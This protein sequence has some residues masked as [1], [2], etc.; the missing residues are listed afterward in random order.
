MSNKSKF[1][2]SKKNSF[3]LY[4]SKSSLKFYEERY[5][6]DYMRD[7]PESKKKKVTQIIKEINLPAYG[8]ALDFGCG[9]GVFTEVIRTC[10]PNWKVYGTDISS[11]AI[12]NAKRRFP[13]C[14]FFDNSEKN[15]K[16]KSFDFIFTNHV[17][18]HVFDLS[19]VL[20][21]MN[22]YMKLNSYMLHFLPCGN[23]NSYEYNMCILR[24]DGINPKQGNRFFFE[25]EGH[26]RRL[27]TEEFSRMTQKIGFNLEKSFY[28]NQYYGAINWITND[29]KVFLIH[30]FNISKA[31]NK[32]A[33]A[34]L[35]RER[36]KLLIISIFR[37]PFS[38][39]S[40]KLNDRNK[41]FIDYLLIIFSLPFYFLSK[42]INNYW[43]KKASI[44]WENKKNCPNG[45]EMALFFKR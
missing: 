2:S 21:E 39:I 20:N 30:F 33:K 27:T 36:N 26:V 44:E 22:T 28:S 23:P 34:K 5:S 31:I 37:F 29:L 18:E 4:D 8:E 40:K 9:N 17:I 1:N 16:K 7:W 38:F 3:N 42:Q 25:D 35:K 15:Y 32:G 41:R 10:L 19:E 43:E 14:I 6:G 11:N 24:K 13:D 45:S 12:N